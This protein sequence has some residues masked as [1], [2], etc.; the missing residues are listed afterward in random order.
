[1]DVFTKKKRSEIMS[2]I[3]SKNTTAEVLLF[4]LLRKEG[5]KFSKHDKSLPGSPDAVL[6]NEKVVIFID[7]EF[8]HGYRFSRW[9][10]RIPQKYWR[11]K[12]E[13]NI[14]RDRLNRKN[15]KKAGWHVVREWSRQFKKDPNILMK[16]LKSFRY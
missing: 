5:Y 8:W 2:K 13:N 6:K 9:K 1:M 16:Q 7:G 10:D 11:I 12:I 15:L 14:K 4:K 3:R